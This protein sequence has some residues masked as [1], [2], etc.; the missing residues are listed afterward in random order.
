[1]HRLVIPDDGAVLLERCDG[2]SFVLEHG[3][4]SFKLRFA[5]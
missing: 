1:L 3:E 2:D 4:A 5:D